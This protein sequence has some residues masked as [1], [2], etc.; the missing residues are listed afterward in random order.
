MLV[1]EAGH[2]VFNFMPENTGVADWGKQTV[3]DCAH[4]TI[5]MAVFKYVTLWKLKMLY[6]YQE[7]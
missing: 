1:A 6:F 3:F 4:I 5:T 7:I 2:G